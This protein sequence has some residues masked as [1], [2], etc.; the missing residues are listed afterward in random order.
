MFGRY[1]GSSY[2]QGKEASHLLNHRILGIIPL[3]ILMVLGAA[4]GSGM[5]FPVQCGYLPYSGHTEPSRGL[6]EVWGLKFRL[7]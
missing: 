3:T 7:G 2:S 6:G 5:F 4:R 1:L